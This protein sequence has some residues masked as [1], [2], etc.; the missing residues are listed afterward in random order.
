MLDPFRCHF[1]TELIAGHNWPAELDLVHRCKHCHSSRAIHGRRDQDASSLGHR[2]DDED[3]WHDRP[4]WPVPLKEWLVGAHILDR[5]D[6]LAGLNF[7]HA[8]D[9]QERVTVRQDIEDAA[10]I[11]RSVF[12]DRDGWNTRTVHLLL[13]QPLK[14]FPYQGR[15]GMVAGAMGDDKPVQVHAQK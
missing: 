1:Q 15:I 11:D 8:I 13:F 14:Q 4:S 2:L 3:A 10:N 5:H 6:G 9:Q 7:E 12:S